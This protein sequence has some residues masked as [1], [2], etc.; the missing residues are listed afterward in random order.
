VVEIVEG[1]AGWRDMKAG[2]RRPRR[3]K[4]KGRT[5]RR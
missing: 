3:R 4:M 1:A 2:I 5:V